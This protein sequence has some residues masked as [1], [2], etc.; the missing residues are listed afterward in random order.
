M[1]TLI[2]IALLLLI[3]LSTASCKNQNTL[4]A[5]TA[6]KNLFKTPFTAI[7]NGISNSQYNSISDRDNKKESIPSECWVKRKTPIE[8][9]SDIEKIANAVR[10]NVCSCVPW[11]SCTTLE[12]PCSRMCPNNFDIFKRPGIKSTGQLSFRENS[13]PFRNGGGGSSITA[14][15]GF[16]WG[17]ASVTSKFNRLAF[18]KENKKPKHSLTP[19]TFE[20]YKKGL[21]YYK[22]LVDKIIDNEPVEIPG[23]KNLNDFASEPGIQE[24]IADQVAESWADRAMSF[25]GLGVAMQSKPASKKDNEKFFSDVMKK[26]DQNQQP[27]IVFTSKGAKFATHAVLVSH[28]E[29]RRDGS[30]KICIRDNNIRRKKGPALDCSDYMVMSKDGSVYYNRWGDLGGL[31]VAFNENPDSLDQFN[32]LKEKCDKDKGCGK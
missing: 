16:C 8:N 3:V 25:S 5:V 22:G 13:L 12:C 27:Q 7:S 31:T 4:G 30:T 15:Q 2:K 29:K 9:L 28:Y 23:F 19:S 10:G 17:H 11:G 18:F 32:N 14:T 21:D 26:V 1:R 24:Y 6:V 20:K